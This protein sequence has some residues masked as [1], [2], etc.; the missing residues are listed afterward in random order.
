MGG[1]LWTSC[2][3]TAQ[4]MSVDVGALISGILAAF[5]MISHKYRADEKLS[6]HEAE[7]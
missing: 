6:K 5:I 4:F 7:A 2:T 1:S 3:A